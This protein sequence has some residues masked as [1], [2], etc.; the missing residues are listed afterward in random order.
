MEWI[1]RLTE[2]FAKLLTWLLSCKSLENTSPQF[3][4]TRKDPAIKP[5]PQSQKVYL[6]WKWEVIDTALT[7]A[8]RS[9]QVQLLP[10]MPHSNSG[11]MKQTPITSCSAVGDVQ[12]NNPS[13]LLPRKVSQTNAEPR[14]FKGGPNLFICALVMFLNRVFRPEWY[15]R[16]PWF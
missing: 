8:L 14:T 2:R 6:E 5:V 9:T 15:D 1:I 12:K 7:A 16:F 3:S 4:F 13:Y 11:K 10:R